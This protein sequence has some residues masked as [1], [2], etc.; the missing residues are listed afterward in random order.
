M[1]ASVTASPRCLGARMKVFPIKLQYDTLYRIA[2]DSLSDERSKQ[3][4]AVN[5]IDKAVLL[6]W[7]PNRGIIACARSNIP[8][9]CRWMPAP[10]GSPRVVLPDPFWDEIYNASRVVPHALP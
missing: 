1:M 6:A 5:P 4:G 9:G 2:D 10:S 3:G 8:M 7:H